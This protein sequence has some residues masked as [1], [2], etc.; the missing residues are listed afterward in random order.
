[1]D[2]L[3]GGRHFHQAIINTLAHK[4]YTH[5]C[6]FLL[7]LSL[8]SRFL[9]NTVAGAVPY[10]SCLYFYIHSVLEAV[11]AIILRSIL[12]IFYPLNITTNVLH[13]L[14]RW[15]FRTCARVR[16]IVYVTIVIAITY[17]VQIFFFLAPCTFSPGA[18][19][20]YRL[21]NNWDAFKER[22]ASEWEQI[23]MIGEFMAATTPLARMDLRLY[24][25]G[26]DLY[27]EALSHV[28]LL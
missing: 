22:Q 12:L 17:G 24:C 26:A 9:L 8:F 21:Q 27:V 2:N 5:V 20:L 4:W 15:I 1:M 28:F 18:N 23:F 6:P 25:A 3:H 13:W 19:E 10:H 7:N 14:S 11:S 16:I